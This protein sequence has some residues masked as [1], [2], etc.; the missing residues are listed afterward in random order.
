MSERAL[1]AHL[2][3][4]EAQNVAHVGGQQGEEGVKGPIVGEVSYDNGPQRSGRHYRAPGDV[5]A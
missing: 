5:A 2:L 3:D 1:T 4:A